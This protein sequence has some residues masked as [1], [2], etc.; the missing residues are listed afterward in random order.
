MQP[1]M[2]QDLGSNQFDAIQLRAQ[3]CASE[4][5]SNPTIITDL[6]SSVTLATIKE[7]DGISDPNKWVDQFFPKA[8]EA[9]FKE[10][11]MFCFQAA[12]EH[13]AKPEV[14]EDIAQDSI[15]ALLKSETE[16]SYIKPW[17][18]RVVTNKLAQYFTERA[19]A[20]EMVIQMIETG[21]FLDLSSKSDDKLEMNKLAMATVAKLLS[22]SDFA[23]FKKISSYKN[24]I[25][26]A[27]A[28]KIP[29]GTARQHSHQIRTNLKSAYLLANGWEGTPE[30]L[31]YHQL[32]TIKNFIKATFM[33]FRGESADPNRK[34]MVAISEELLY[35]AFQGATILIDWGIDMIGNQRYQLYLYYMKTDSPQ[36]LVLRIRF[37]KIK[38]II[39]TD[40]RIAELVATLDLPQNTK[41]LIRDGKP[42]FTFEEIKALLGEKKLSK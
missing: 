42:A 27:R 25:E 19:K 20:D 31:D 1:V 5:F 23:R 39:I 40:C 17:L 35:D 21:K 7:W 15:A 16:I 37:N 36:M 9:Y 6:V 41:L 3:K 29:V 22:R 11:R 12:M 18:K 26:Y 13:I 10:L 32:K 34:R 33:I 24:L 4:A 14:A 38:R 2:T 28:M 30:I 8:V